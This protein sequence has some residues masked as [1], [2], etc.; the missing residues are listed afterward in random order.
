MND[1]SRE[2]RPNN[3]KSVFLLQTQRISSED[4]QRSPIQKLGRRVRHAGL[5]VSMRLLI[6]GGTR[7]LGP[8]LAE[9]A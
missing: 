9:D 3:P 7:F 2:G 4:R 1:R 5:I 6:L 8:A